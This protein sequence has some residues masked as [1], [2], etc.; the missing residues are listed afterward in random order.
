M[1]GFFNRDTESSPEDAKGY[2][3]ALLRFIKEELQKLEGGEGH[4]IKGLCLF[5]KTNPDDQHIFESAVY[6]DKPERFKEEVQ[7]IADDFALDLPPNWAMEVSFIDALPAEAKKMEG[8]NAGVYIR[9]KDKIIQKSATARIFILNGEAE[10]DEYIIKSGNTRI[11]IG[12]GQRVQMN[13][14]F[15][16]INA[17][18]FPPESTDEANK[19]ISRQ[20]AHI[21]WSNENAAFLLFADEGGVPPGNKVKIKSSLTGELIKLH[22]TEI[23]HRLEDGDQVII[24][25]KAALEFKY[26]PGEEK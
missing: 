20:H 13:D 3:E 22:S 14:G 18:A 15:F 19:Y 17:I 8:L 10:E 21:E 12:R 1:F 26:I 6:M 25:E 16:R 11:N 2:R 23:G 4:H 24:G 7:K 5:I 9:T